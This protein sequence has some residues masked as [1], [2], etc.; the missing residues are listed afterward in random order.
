MN[1]DLM[2][3]LNRAG[4]RIKIAESLISAARMMDDPSE[5]LP[6]IIRHLRL[7]LFEVIKDKTTQIPA[8]GSGLESQPVEKE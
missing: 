8:H 5:M 7:A 2:I 6:D 4:A 3:S 1:I